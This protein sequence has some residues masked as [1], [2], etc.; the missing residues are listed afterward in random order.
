MFACLAFQGCRNDVSVQ[1][2]SE[3]ASHA[4]AVEDKIES[5][6]LD[7]VL[8]WPY[9]HHTPTEL[10][11]MSTHSPHLAEEHHTEEQKQVGRCAAFP[12]LACKLWI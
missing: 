2:C 7:A 3:S 10:A 8:C 12:L 11:M 5:N 4:E 1:V 9:L 6:K